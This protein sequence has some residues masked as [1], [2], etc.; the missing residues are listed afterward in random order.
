M[1]NPSDVSSMTSDSESGSILHTNR[2][3]IIATAKISVASFRKMTENGID[4]D[5]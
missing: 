3:E 1:A 2:I 5:R 4:H